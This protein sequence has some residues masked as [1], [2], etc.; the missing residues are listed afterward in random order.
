MVEYST[1][2]VQELAAGDPMPALKVIATALVMLLA[3]VLS[4]AL[5]W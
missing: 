5:S 3:V 2:W 1:R 4:G